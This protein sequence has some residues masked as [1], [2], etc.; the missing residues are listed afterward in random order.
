LKAPEFS[1]PDLAGKMHSLSMVHGG[2]ALLNFWA[3]SA[4]VC[5][6]QLRLLDQR[7]QSLQILSINV[8]NPAD[9]QAARSLATQEKLSFPVL[10]ATEDVAGIYN[11][12][13]RYLFDRR[14]DL[15]IPTSFLLD[16]EGMIVK[17]YQGPI[18]PQR[19]LQ[20]ARSVPATAESRR[21]KALPFAGA[22][23]QG[24]FQR[25]D[26]TYGVALFQHGYL[27]QAAESFQQVIAAKPEDPEGYYNL[28]TLNLRRNDLKQAR[29]FLE[30]TLK[31]RPNYPEAW[32]N[33]GMIAAQEGQ[34]E[35][36][37]KN[38]QQSLLLRPSYG[39]ALLNL[40]NIYRR[41]KSFAQAQE[42]LNQALAVQPDDPEVNYSL[43]MLYA[44]QGQMQQ[45]SDY[46]HR[47]VDL[48]P[49]Y[50][51]ALN[52]LGVLYVR[53]Q[54]YAKAEEA[55]KTCL[56]VA[57]NFDQSYMNLAR[58][59]VL[60]NDKQRAREVLQELLQR[61]PENPGAKQALEMLP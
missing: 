23:Y 49:D 27:E 6:D 38:F 18:D 59:Y 48:R 16:K 20:D 10:F 26:F 3:V 57:P 7:S 36:A 24:A 50:P 43:G 42:L 2:F 60:R 30:Q 28:G 33:L 11:I 32:N 46:L 47:A 17:V 31:L 41:Q 9:A 13:Y 4:P 39:T 53:G 8:D 1:L 55:F 19:L 61:Q 22:T 45:A 15:A 12:I 56:R 51:E 37:V 29:Y 44:Q 40:G 14:R 5:R 25:N 58:L 35:E 34:P 52:N 21:Q 54:D